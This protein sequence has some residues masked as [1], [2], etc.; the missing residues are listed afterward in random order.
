MGIADRVVGGVTQ[1]DA[2]FHLARRQ[3]RQAQDLGPV[4][5][6]IDTGHE[7]L[8]RPSGPQ[9]R[10]PGCPRVSATVALI[11]VAGLLAACSSSDDKA[12]DDTVEDGA[13]TTVAAADDSSATSAVADGSLTLEA[14][15]TRPE[16]VTGGE[17]LVAVSGDAADPEALSVTLDGGVAEVAWTEAEG[18][19]HGLI[20]GLEPGD[21]ELMATAGDET[22]TLT[23]TAHPVTG[24]VFSGSPLPLEACSTETYGLGAPVDDDCSAAEPVATWSY[25]DE[26][27][28]R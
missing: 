20:T 26:A 24:P 23:V 27:G 16:Y 4:D 17:V 5:T 19:V 1:N 10:D 8:P 3:A 21:H 2:A 18:E 12:G 22:A 9:K 15:S 14:A 13:T 7:Q 28:E 11:V 25:I 6:V